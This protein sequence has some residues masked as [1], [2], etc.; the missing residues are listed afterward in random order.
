MT[1][2]PGSALALA[3]APAFAVMAAWQACAGGDPG[4]LCADLHA[5][6]LDGMAPMY[7]MMSAFHC[8][9]WL[10]LLRRRLRTTAA[11]AGS[12]PLR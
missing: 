6:P 9:P 4:P 8:A 5:S 1:G 11:L 10:D 7:A 2:A 12:P 3:A